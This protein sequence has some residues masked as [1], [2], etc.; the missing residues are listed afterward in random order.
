MD[1][2]AVAV[3]EREQTGRKG[4]REVWKEK[5]QGGRGRWTAAHRES[6]G[7]EEVGKGK[8]EGDGGGWREANYIDY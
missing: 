8:E 6:E 1:V 4:G 7:G 3:S 2:R 5:E